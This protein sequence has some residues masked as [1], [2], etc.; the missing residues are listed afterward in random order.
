M[1]AFISNA[2]VKDLTAGGQTPVVNHT[3][4]FYDVVSKCGT[5]FSMQCYTFLGGGTHDTVTFTTEQANILGGGWDAF[6]TSHIVLPADSNK[7]WEDTLWYKNI[8]IKC[9][10]SNVA[11][12]YGKFRAVIFYGNP[13]NN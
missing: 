6:G 7:T 13:V 3:Y 1:L 9:V 12:H 5:P 2:Q 4:Y 11:T 8:R 10:T